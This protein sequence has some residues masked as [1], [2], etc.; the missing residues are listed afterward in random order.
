MSARHRRRPVAAVALTAALTAGA[1]LLLS[2]CGPDDTGTAGSPAGSAAPPGSAAPAGSSRPAPPTT[3]AAPRTPAGTRSSAPATPASGPNGTA[4][5]KLTVSDGTP[6]VLMNGTTVDFHTQVRDLAWNPDGSRAA[7]IDGDGDLVVTDPDGSH[8]RVVAKN[9]G[10]QTWSHPTWQVSPA[11][12]NGEPAKNNLFFAVDQGGT[13]RLDTVP[14]TATD[15]QPA[16]LS[17]NPVFE[18]HPTSLPQTGNT[19]PNAA[20][21][22]GFSVYANTGDGQVYLRDDYLRQQGSAY[23][24][25]SEPAVNGAGT[26]LVFVRSV[27][28]HDHLFTAQLDQQNPSGT[29]LTPNATTDYTEPAWS[30][31]G[32]TIAARTPQGVVTLPADG[33]AAPELTVTTPGLPAYRD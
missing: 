32:S 10:G 26:E 21:S 8:R 33:S 29:D 30:P 3:S 4:H 9:P 22:H 15:A 18:D 24:H 20:G 31:D 25:G 7:F 14:A 28:G 17:L 16:A 5:S 6:L 13:T 27:G 23:T 11:D 1:A 2:A 19:W 12:G